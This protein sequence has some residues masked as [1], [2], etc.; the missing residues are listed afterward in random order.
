MEILL[1][2]DGEKTKPIQSQFAGESEHAQAIPSTT[3]R[4][5]PKA[6]GFEAATLSRPALCAKIR[7][8]NLKKQSQFVLVQ[9]SAFCGQR[10]DEEKCL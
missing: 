4:T 3:L 8:G 1:S 7:K 2:R 5:G 9:C 10:Q 6:F